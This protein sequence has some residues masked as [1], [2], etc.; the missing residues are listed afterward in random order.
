MFKYFYLSLVLLSLFL[1][2]SS[3]D[4]SSTTSDNNERTTEHKLYSRP[5]TSN[6]IYLIDYENFEFVRKIELGIPESM[7]C[8][9][10]CLSTKHDYFL[11]NAWD[12]ENNGESKILVYDINNE[13]IISVFSLGMGMLGAVRLFPANITEEPGLAYLYTHTKGLYLFDFLE[14]KIL[15]QIFKNDG[16]QLHKWI[17]H[18]P[19]GKY[20][21]VLTM[22]GEIQPSIIE[23]F[24]T[25]SMLKNPLSVLNADNSDSI[26]V[27]DFLFSSSGELIYFSDRGRGRDMPVRVDKYDVQNR[28]LIKSNLEIPFSLNPFYLAYSSQRNELYTVGGLNLLYII[29]SDS[30]TIKATVTLSGKKNGVSRLLLRPDEQILFISAIDS[31]ILYIINLNFRSIEKTIDLSQPYFLTIP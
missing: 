28:I 17:R 2:I 10:L 12:Q 21:A 25:E 4:D 29:D 1:L 11:F 6:Y 27:D 3:C 16:L 24:D 31:D 18:S 30:L 14:K 7:I 5:G 8:Y 13:K 22:Y 19:N 9:G 26:S 23:V 20:T 15:E